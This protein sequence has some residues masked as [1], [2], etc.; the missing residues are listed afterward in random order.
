MMTQN[1]NFSIGGSYRQ[2]EQGL[3]LV[4]NFGLS[5]RLKENVDLVLDELYN[6]DVNTRIVTGDH[7]ESALFIAR[8]LGII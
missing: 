4:A 8:E 5:D 7:K 6:A 1:H 3:I 2:L